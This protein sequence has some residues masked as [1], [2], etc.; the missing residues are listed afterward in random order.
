M[1]KKNIKLNKKQ[2][3]NRQGL[4][5]TQLILIPSETVM[6]KIFLIRGKKVMIDSDLA[7]LYG[8]KTK[9]LNLAVKRN[10]ERFPIDFM[11]KLNKQ[12]TEIW[13]SQIDIHST[14]NLRLQFETSNKRGG[15]RY[16]PYVFTEEGVAML[17]SVLNSK[18]AIQTNIQIIRTFTKLREML[19]TNKELREKI[20]KLE[21]KYDQNFRIVF[22]TIQSFLK[23][24]NKSKSKIGF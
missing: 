21:R 12:E 8:T 19:M 16:L 4:V 17:S 9:E 24:D 5:K 1:Q 18:R 14:V 20:E 15:R 22:Q 3:L 13:K 6:S 7:N 2:N 10:L 23:E 11:F